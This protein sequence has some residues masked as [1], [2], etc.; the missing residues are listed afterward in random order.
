MYISARSLPPSAG[1]NI[2][3]RVDTISLAIDSRPT[4][5]KSGATILEV[6]RDAGIYIPTICSCPAIKPLGTCRMC[7]VQVEGASGLLTS[8]NA[9][10]EDGMVVQVS[11]RR[12][13][14]RPG[15]RLPKAHPP[16]WWP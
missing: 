16:G 2:G 3:L 12:G 14:W 7:L 10:A 15:P 13:R 8:C 6:A 4:V 5:A 1:F 11:S 9:Q